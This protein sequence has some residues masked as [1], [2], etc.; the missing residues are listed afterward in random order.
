MKASKYRLENIE[1]ATRFITEIDH[2]TQFRKIFIIDRSLL[3]SMNYFYIN[4]LNFK[5]DSF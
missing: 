2:E 1:Q 5:R 4:F 3:A